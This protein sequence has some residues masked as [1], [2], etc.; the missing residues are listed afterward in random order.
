MLKSC[1]QYNVKQKQRLCAKHLG[2]SSSEDTPIF[3]TEQLTAK[4]ARL[5]FLARELVKSKQFKYCW[6][7]YGRI[8][9]RKDDNSRIIN[10]TNEL[11]LKDL[12][13]SVKWLFV[14]IVSVNLNITLN[15]CTTLNTHTYLF[16][17]RQSIPTYRTT[18][19]YTYVY[20][21][22]VS[23]YYIKLTALNTNSYCNI[24]QHSPIT[25]LTTN[26][27]TY[28]HLVIIKYNI[29]L[30][31]YIHLTI[32]IIYS[33]HNTILNRTKHIS[34]T[35]K[36]PTDKYSSEQT[37]CE[38]DYL[39]Q[40]IELPTVTITL[41]YKNYLITNTF[42]L[43]YDSCRFII[44]KPMYSKLILIYFSSDNDWFTAHSKRYR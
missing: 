4:M 1:K 20:S 43:N 25:Y 13:S 2:L 40:P 3:V 17:K 8:Y 16:T 32:T 24:K 41:S 27:P 30:H 33:N 6:T 31:T 18:I 12:S 22:I 38:Y 10:I 37:C 5:H 11:Q 34:I 28:M 14:Q 44:H 39:I 26:S 19:T 15:L 7:N 35:I 36:S 9:L 29:K 42:L 21:A 23:Y